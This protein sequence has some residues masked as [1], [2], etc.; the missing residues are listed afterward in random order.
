MAAACCVGVDAP[1][2]LAAMGVDVPLMQ[3][4]TQLLLPARWPRLAFVRWRCSCAHVQDVYDDVAHVQEMEAKGV[5]YPSH[6]REAH[7]REV[8]EAAYDAREAAYAPRPS[9]RREPE[10]VAAATTMLS[11][12]ESFQVCRP[13]RM[14]CALCDALCDACL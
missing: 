11:P 9:Q 4:H 1:L 3:P 2:V 8:R 13:L 10:V 14:Q 12:S 7:G 5:R 6:D